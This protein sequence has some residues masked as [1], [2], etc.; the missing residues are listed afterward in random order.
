MR[1]PVVL[2]AI[3]LLAVVFWGV[4]GL[5]VAGVL[6]AFGY[7]ISLRLNPR[8]RHRG[9]G[10]SGRSHGWIYTWSYHRCQG[11]GGSGRMIRRGAARWGH[12][13]I[14]DEAEARRRAIEKARQ[15]RAWR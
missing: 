14:R 10:G 8:V 4:P 13:A 7:W 15:A 12:Q 11:C 6:L 5:T 9:C 1:F 2:I 3:L